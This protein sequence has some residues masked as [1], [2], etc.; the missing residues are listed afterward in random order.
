MSSLPLAVAA[1][2]TLSPVH[3]AKLQSPAVVIGPKTVAAVVP[4]L[5]KALPAASAAA[6]SS[7]KSVQSVSAAVSAA[8]QEVAA[9]IEAFS[10]GGDARA[11]GEAM[12]AALEHS[13]AV[14]TVSSEDPVGALRP[15]YGEAL[16]SAQAAAVK[17]GLPKPRFVSARL[18][19]AG[20]RFYFD[21]G[22]RLV[23]AAID[24]KGQAWAYAYG[25][26]KVAAS[27]ALTQEAFLGRALLPLEQVLK[28][29]SEIWVVPAAQLGARVVV[30]PRSRD[31]WYVIDSE[32]GSRTFVNARTGRA[33]PV[34]SPA[35]PPRARIEAMA[36]S[37]AS[38]KGYP[39]SYTEYSLVVATA[40]D[41]LRRDGATLAQFNLFHRLIDA[42]PLRGGRFN[43]Y[44]GD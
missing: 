8:G 41:D 43:P 32:D 31:L 2:F 38:Q 24:A 19:S 10:N 4:A 40:E 42:A 37:V 44:S 16:Q 21:A 7:A 23:L 27:L 26:Q 15:L 28:N 5:P 18:E 3:A 25:P 33:S 1:V 11:T 36:R 29:I 9:R 14:A 39:W 30:L 20:W 35:A 22:G 13:A 6:A 12:Q 17:A 34:V